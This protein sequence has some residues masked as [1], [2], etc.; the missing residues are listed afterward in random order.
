MIYTS[1]KIFPLHPQEKHRPIK[2]HTSKGSLQIFPVVGSVPVSVLGSVCL[3]IPDTL[4]TSLGL[5]GHGLGPLLHVDT[6][7]SWLG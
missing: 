5:V 4:A 2:E 7:M 3:L 6:M 1:I